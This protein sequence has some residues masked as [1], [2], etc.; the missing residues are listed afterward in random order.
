MAKIANILIKTPPKHGINAP[1]ANVSRELHALF[2][3]SEIAILAVVIDHADALQ[4]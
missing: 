3:S 1:R 4:I 2:R